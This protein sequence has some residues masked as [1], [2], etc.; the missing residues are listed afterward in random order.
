MSSFFTIIGV[1]LG[2]VISPFLVALLFLVYGY[3]R[4][5]VFGIH[6]QATLTHTKPYLHRRY[7][8][9]AEWKDPKTNHI[10][11]FSTPTTKPDT[12]SVGSSIPVV[13]DPK[14]PNWRLIAFFKELPLSFI[15]VH[16][17]LPY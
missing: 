11:R 8:I 13:F 9:F 15:R 3:I 4:L 16:A 10:Y 14:K 5:M 6:V 17:T 7:R 2:L 12:Y 1:I